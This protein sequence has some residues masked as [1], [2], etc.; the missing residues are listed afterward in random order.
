MISNST[1]D[2]IPQNLTA[3]A[4]TTSQIKLA[5][6]SASGNEDGFAI[7]QQQPDGS[8]AEVDNVAAGVTNDTIKNLAEGTD[9]NFRGE[10][11]GTAPLILGAIP[12]SALLSHSV[13]SHSIRS[14]RNA[15]VLGS[16]AT[17]SCI[18]GL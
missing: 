1:P 7:E 16:R 17:G 11:I 8:W 9:Y 5:W 18:S 12:F 2:P 14:A 13:R 3:T 6:D 15:S 10:M 4:L